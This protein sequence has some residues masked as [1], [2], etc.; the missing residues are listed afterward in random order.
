MDRDALVDSLKKP[1]I[2]DL[3]VIGGGATGCG[4]ALD[5]A[6]RGLKVALAERGDFGGGTSGRS[7]KLVHGGVRYLEAALLGLDRVQFNLVRDGLHER[8]ILLRIAPHLCHRVSLVTPLYRF[9][10]VPYVWAGL[11]L[12]DLLAGRLGLGPSRFLGR[13]EL[14]RRFPMIRSKSLKGG[15]L[16]YDGQFNDARMNLAL[17]Q[18]ARSQG[19]A[20]AN[21]LEVESLISDAGRVCGARVR[22]LIRGDGW[23]IRARVVVNACGAW[24][25]QVR[26]LDDPAAPAILQVSSGSHLV[27]PARFAP[28]DAG[29]T[30]PKTEDGRVLFVLPW[31]GGCLVGTTDEPATV[32]DHPVV[33]GS[34]IDYLLRHLARYFELQV[35]RADIRAAWSGLRPLVR[36]PAAS[37]TARLARDHVVTAAA[38]GLITIVGGKWT[39]YRKMAQDTVDFAL[40]TARLG[41]AGACR[42]ET[43]PLMGAAGYRG[44]AE[45]ASLLAAAHGLEP[46][47]A[48]HFASSYGSRAAEVALLC[49][50]EL[51]CRLAA[52]YPYLRGEV[53]YAVRQEMAQRVSDLVARRLPLALLDNRAAREAAPAV[54]ELM[55]GELGW[56]KTR[57]QEELRLVEPWLADPPLS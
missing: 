41:P 31:M 22:D 42:T 36:D 51:A 35:R 8:G 49:R 57:C 1:V 46:E 23:E 45:E 28:A 18:T 26:R 52:E 12:Y 13:R 54:L 4:I 29:I 3:L 19:A 10:E 37:D 21:Y 16:Y 17:A 56:D 14:L 34:D 30:I 6:S 5:A 53:L 24:S 40:R 55:A 50:G 44:A 11:K 9:L 15:V 20:L 38:S 2:F 25:D 32:T 27:L 43:L 39:T 47:T 48:L 7:T 33:A